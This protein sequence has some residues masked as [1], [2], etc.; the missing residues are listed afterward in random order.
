MS[1]TR[2]ARS[3]ELQIQPSLSSTLVVGADIAGKVHVAH[4]RNARGVGFGKPLSFDN[5]VDVPRDM[6]L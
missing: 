5:T 2:T 3:A 6:T 1:I 4:A